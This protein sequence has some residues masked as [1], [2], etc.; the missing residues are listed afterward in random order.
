MSK[1]DIIQQQK[2]DKLLLGMKSSIKAIRKATVS[3]VYL[4]KNCP[5]VIVE[6]IKHYAALSGVTVERLTINCDEL[7]TM[8]KKPFFVS[9]VGVKN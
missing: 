3:K 5:E 6:D 9:V 1:E 8:C 2:D 4:A 7:A